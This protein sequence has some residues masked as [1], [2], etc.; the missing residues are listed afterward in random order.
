MVRA[1]RT[2]SVVLL[3]LAAWV[4]VARADAVK[5]GGIAAPAPAAAMGAA[6]AKSDTATAAPAAAAGITS[7]DSANAAKAVEPAKG[8]QVAPDDPDEVRGA[9][10]VIP[11]GKEAIV[12]KLFEPYWS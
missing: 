2:L 7:A 11:P 4:G 1:E 3:T 10:P 5:E 9:H 6:A 8:T 12:Q